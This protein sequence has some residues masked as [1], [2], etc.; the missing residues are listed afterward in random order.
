MGEEEGGTS[1]CGEINLLHAVSQDLSQDEARNGKC[2]TFT[3]TTPSA[4][5]A[6]A[7]VISTPPLPPPL[8]FWFALTFWRVD[9]EV[10][11]ASEVNRGP[12]IHNCAG[13][14]RC[15]CDVKT[16]QQCR[17]CGHHVWKKRKF[18]RKLS[19]RGVRLAAYETNCTSRTVRR[20]AFNLQAFWSF[21]ASLLL[22]PLQV[23]PRQFTA[24]FATLR[25]VGRV[26]DT[27]IDLHLDNFNIIH[28]G[29]R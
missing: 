20:T 12:G 27:R 21:S 5:W 19:S 28:Y 8:F 9:A 2:A 18:S 14:E 3:Q 1:N 24:V 17:C 25:A 6:F 23:C 22:L 11:V 26:S 10:I 7:L 15:G 13:S 29:W 16:T 4:L